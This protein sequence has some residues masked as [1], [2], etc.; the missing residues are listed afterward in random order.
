[1]NCSIK[2]T[3]T[4]P[5]PPILILL[6]ATEHGS[7]SGGEDGQC[8]SVFNVCRELLLHTNLTTLSCL[9]SECED[10]T[11]TSTSSRTGK[12][13]GKPRSLWPFP[14]LP[15]TSHF[16]PFSHCDFSL[17]LHS[18][19]YGYGFLMVILVSLGSLLGVLIVPLIDK[20][21][22]KK[23]K[24]SKRATVYKYLYFFM[25][26]LGTSALLSDAVLHLIPHV[27]PYCPTS[28]LPTVTHCLTSIS[29]WVGRMEC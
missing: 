11:D 24:R 17:P 21:K 3:V 6:P 13:E 1:M 9:S 7:G 22:D 14:F 15:L 12:A 27:S 4:L 2:V 20:D 28:A 10:P 23:G 19:A 25:I 26:A 29:F 5:P 8:V 16:S 18:S